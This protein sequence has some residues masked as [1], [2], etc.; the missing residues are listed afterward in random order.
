MFK[1]KKGWFVATAGQMHFSIYSL[2][3]MA[4]GVVFESGTE[5]FYVLSS[6]LYKYKNSS[7]NKTMLF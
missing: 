7:Q 3:L 6:L 5:L 4:G 1:E 2:P